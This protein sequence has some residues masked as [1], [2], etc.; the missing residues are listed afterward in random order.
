MQIMNWK[1]WQ[2]NGRKGKI[3]T[4]TYIK[5]K[6]NWQS[7]KHTK[8]TKYLFKSKKTT[9]NKR[10]VTKI[11]AD[12]ELKVV[13]SRAEPVRIAFDWPGRECTQWTRENSTLKSFLSIN[14][15]SNANN[16][17]TFVTLFPHSSTRERISLWY[18]Y[19]F[20]KLI[21]C[22]RLKQYSQKNHSKA[23]CANREQKPK[24]MIHN[25][26]KFFCETAINI[27]VISNHYSFRVL[28]V[29]LFTYIFSKIH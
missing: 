7:G 23:S 26:R 15:S 16:K 9:S 29:K 25:T 20:S 4:K 2:S 21:Q 6:R 13:V 17:K 28:F 22:Q 24:I 3:N 27:L 14:A 5:N 10:L 8:T 18:P 19:P 1:Q 11:V 12:W